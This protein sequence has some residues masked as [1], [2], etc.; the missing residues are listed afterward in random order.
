M[1]VGGR[2]QGRLGLV[3]GEGVR[4]KVKWRGNKKRKE[5]KICMRRGGVR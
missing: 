3:G 5:R 1:G 2:K 4:N